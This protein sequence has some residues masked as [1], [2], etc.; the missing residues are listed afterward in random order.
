L[1]L[2]FIDSA[3]LF[4]DIGKLEKTLGSQSILELLVRAGITIH[5]YDTLLPFLSHLTKNKSCG[6]I[7]LDMR[8]I[9]AA[10]HEAIPLKLRHV[11]TSPIVLLKAVKNAH[12]ASS[13]RACHVRDGAAMVAFLHQLEQQIA[14]SN[15]TLTE[16]ELDEMVT[17]SRAEFS[18]DKFLEP[19]FATIAGVNSN[20]AI[21]HYRAVNSTC[22]R[23]T[24]DDLLLLDS[25][26]QY[27][28]GTTDVTRTIHMG[29]PTSYQ[30]EM[31]TRVLQG[32][33]AVASTI[34]PTGTMGG[35][36]DILARKSLWRV[37][38]DYNHGTG[39]GVGA[40]LNVHEGPQR[41]S[42]HPDSI[43]LQPNMIISNEPGF[44]ENGHFG[45]RIENLLIVTKTSLNPIMG[46]DFL[47]F[48]PLTLVPIQTKLIKLELL[49]DDERD[50]LNAYHQRV[51]DEVTPLLH[52]EE[53]KLWLKQATKPI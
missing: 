16:V 30:Q 15:Q 24:R 32:H 40:A 47:C 46:K 12:E 11:A 38:K 37:A 52:T 4:I 3:H 27:L 29:Q 44:Y 48:E 25:G 18:P 23:L 39:H 20:S 53:Q 42:P 26:G 14:V 50:Y 13:M 49:T 2:F 34:F 19:S 9:N 33:I 36:L 1:L 41:I 21:I 51:C 5:S 35:Q 6:K 31:Y 7:W 8:S 10:V 17:A 43:P 22:K 28:D 45:I